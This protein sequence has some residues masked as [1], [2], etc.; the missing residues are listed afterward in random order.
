MVCT[1][2]PN[3]LLLVNTLATVQSGVIH[4]RVANLGD[5]DVWLKPRTRIGVIHAVN[6]VQATSKTAVVWRQA[7]PSELELDLQEE[8]PVPPDGSQCPVN[9]EDYDCTQAQKDQLRHLFHKHAEVFAQDEDDLGHTETVKHHIKCTD[10]RPTAQPFRR[11]PPNQLEEVK[12]HIEKL[13]HRGVITESH[14]PY[15]SPIVVRKKDLSLRLCV[16]TDA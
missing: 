12:A 11:I 8:E 3:N 9:L 10:D 1:P 13:L 15:A 6:E 16:D 2:A 7:V 5:E 14:S 4:V